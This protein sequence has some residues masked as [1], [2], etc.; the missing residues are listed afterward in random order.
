M[1]RNRSVKLGQRN[2]ALGMLEAGMAVAH[3]ARNLGVSH[4]TISR[5]R[6]KFNATG[7]LKDRPRTSRPR[8]T[9][10]NEDRYITLTSHH[11][12][13]ASFQRITDHFYTTTRTM[14]K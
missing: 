3:V 4:C 6:T 11:N 13:F 1:G 7:L 14:I 9:T 5:L 12:C 10:A 8:K 2:R